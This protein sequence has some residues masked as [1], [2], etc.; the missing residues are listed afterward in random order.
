M[1]S[2][3]FTGFLNNTELKN[4]WSPPGIEPRTA[5]LYSAQTLFHWATTTTQRTNT[6]I[7]I[8]LRGTAMLQSHSQQTNEISLF[9]KYS[10]NFFP[11]LIYHF[12]ISF[13]AFFYSLDVFSLFHSVCS[14]G[15]CRSSVAERLCAIQVVL[16]SIPGGDQIFL[17]LYCL[18]SLWKRENTSNE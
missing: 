2:L 18:K 15:G 8:L 12:T 17:I 10:L 11:H 4:I 13:S 16:G 6:P 3:S 14:P 1:Y 7:L 9:S 5:C